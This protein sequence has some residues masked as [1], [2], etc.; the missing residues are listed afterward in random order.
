MPDLLLELFSEEIPARMQ[1]NAARNLRKLITDS[2][3]DAGLTYEGAKEYWTPRRLVIDIRNLT[4][5]S[6]D[7]KEERK[8]PRTDAPQKAIEGFMRGVGLQSI[9]QAKIQS[10]PK[11]GEYYVA[12]IEKT[13]SRRSPNNCIYY[14]TDHR[15]FFLAQIHAMGQKF[16]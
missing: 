7:I 11:K 2:L 14:A 8:G 3:V 9:D 5:R 15:Q 12:I 13:R 6:A 10:D 4:T 1:A 16:S